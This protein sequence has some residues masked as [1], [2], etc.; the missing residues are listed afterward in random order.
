MY[1]IYLYFIV[2][3]MRFNWWKKWETAVESLTCPLSMLSR[4]LEV[5]LEQADGKNTILFF[6]LSNILN[7]IAQECDFWTEL[8][9][10]FDGKSCDY[11]YD[12]NCSH[13][14]H[15]PQNSNQCC[16]PDNRD[17]RVGAEIHRTKRGK[18]QGLRN[19][20][21]FSVNDWKIIL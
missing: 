14:K 8:R 17:D 9:S 20:L 13:R 10:L 11:K 21:N 15:S 19:R 7:N 18:S 2:L 16:L 1:A 5:K 4:L 3:G 6:F 12:K